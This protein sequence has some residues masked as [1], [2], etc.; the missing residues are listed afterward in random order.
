[1]LDV[2][3]VR[4]LFLSCRPH[5]STIA[6]L[7]TPRNFPAWEHEETN[8]NANKW[9]KSQSRSHAYRCMS[10]SMSCSHRWSVGIS[11]LGDAPLS[12]QQNHSSS[13][14]HISLSL[15]L[16]FFFFYSFIALALKQHHPKQGDAL[17]PNGE[18][19]VWIRWKPGS[20]FEPLTPVW[21][22]Q[23]SQCLR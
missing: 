15:P 19:L 6:R 7:T 11:A 17:P 18:C 12:C 5:D 9:T 16:F 13:Q 3:D 23:R 4:G 20:S 21:T 8:A 2:K 14:G 1:M 22:L 10:L